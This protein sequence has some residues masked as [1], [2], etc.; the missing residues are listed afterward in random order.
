MTSRKVR[1]LQTA[2]HG[3][4]DALVVALGLL[5]WICWTACAVLNAL[6]SR[7][8]AAPVPAAWNR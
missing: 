1:P 6:F 7:P 4:R 8:Q 5:A 3:R 2:P